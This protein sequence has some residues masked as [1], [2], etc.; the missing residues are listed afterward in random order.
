ML[1][2]GG[3]L[4]RTPRVRSRKLNRW[5]RNVKPSLPI[6]H[7]VEGNKLVALDGFNFERHKHIIGISG[8]GKSSFLACIC[9]LLLRMGISFFLLDP[10]GDL[11]TLLLPLLA[12]SD[13]FTNPRAY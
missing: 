11:G 3:V 7:T 10:A 8:S 4:L 2:R 9:I 6:G 12:S 1:N 13:F 5:Q